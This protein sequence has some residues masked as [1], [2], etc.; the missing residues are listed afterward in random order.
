MDF[1]FKLSRSFSLTLGAGAGGGGSGG[2]NFKAAV[3]SPPASSAQA[4]NS[5][6]KIGSI[7]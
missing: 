4:W 3:V 7:A 5:P 6:S 2:G 1:D